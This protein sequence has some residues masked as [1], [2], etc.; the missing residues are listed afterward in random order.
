MLGGPKPPTWR[1]TNRT[2]VRSNE[3]DADQRLLV[4]VLLHVERGL[5]IFAENLKRHLAGRKLI[6]VVDLDRG[7]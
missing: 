7:Y 4:D 1:R 6:N 3:G 2:G 5:D